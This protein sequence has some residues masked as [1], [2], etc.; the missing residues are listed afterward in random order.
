MQATEELL[1]LKPAAIEHIDRP[2]FD[3]TR[4]EREYQ[5]VR[6]LL[7]LDSK[8]CGAILIVEFFEG[9][10]ERLFE[11]NKKKLG[12]RKLIL[13]TPEQA[14]P[15][16]GASQGGTVFAD[17]SW[18]GDAKPACFIEDAAVRA[19]GFARVCHRTGRL[20]E[21]SG[22]ERFCITADAASRLL[23]VRC[24]ICT[25]PKTLK[26]FPADCRRSF[27]AGF[28]IQRLPRGRAWR[29]HCAHGISETT[30]RPGAL[31]A[32]AGNQTVV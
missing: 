24:W 14:D 21:A 16:W 12:L 31:P 29:G 19:T 17:E 30:G 15:V 5:A 9:A 1:H 20:D 10:R 23:H 11:L 13:E 2:L 27:R 8:P 6:D 18:R 4:G 28:A 25:A 3:E 32:H 22:C 7:E 26:K